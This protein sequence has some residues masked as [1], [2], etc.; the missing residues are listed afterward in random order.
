MSFHAV[1]KAVE[2][3]LSGNLKLVF[4][5]MANY[6]DEKDRCYPSQA[7]L[8]R[9]AGVSEKTIQ[10]AIEKLEEIGF[11]SVLRKGT[12]NKSSV[13]CLNFK[14]EGSQNV[15][16]DNLTGG[17]NVHAGETN[18]LVG[19]DN[20]SSQGGQNVHRSYQ[21]T[22]N[23]P[24]N[25]PINNTGVAKK[26]K[27]SLNIDAEDVDLPNYVNRE[28]WI[29]YCRMRKAKRVEIK[30]IGTLKKCLSD[31]EKL[32][33]RDP[34]KAIAV[35]DQSIGNTWTGLFKVKEELTPIK[36]KPSS[37]H[38]FNDKKYEEHIPDIYK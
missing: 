16:P 6:A 27:K 4:I 21:D 8:A 34:Q 3:P 7:T 32:S 13:Y 1:A 5:L 18:C 17:Q 33:G 19:V 23:D 15:T 20:L 22:I 12:G 25:D 14:V 9:Q 31:L 30:T 26:S 2:A 24:I 28:K 36:P 35:L 38:S 37:H 10:R 11:V 29:E